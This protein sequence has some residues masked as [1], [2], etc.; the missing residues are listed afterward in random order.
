M[1]VLL[2]SAHSRHSVYLC[3][4]LVGVWRKR[5]IPLEGAEWTSARG[6]WQVGR[7]DFHRSPTLYVLPLGP[8]PLEVSWGHK[9]SFGQWTTRGSDLGGSVKS[10][11]LSFQ[12]F[13]PLKACTETAEPQEQSGLVC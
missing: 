12:F 7:T 2:M 11:C 6:I 3:Q 9:I 4:S 13:L 5:G 1:S 10:L 8:S